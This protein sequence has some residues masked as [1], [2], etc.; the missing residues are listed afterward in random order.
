M[1]CGCF[2]GLWSLIDPPVQRGVRPH[3]ELWEQEKAMQRALQG[4][5]EA[6]IEGL[7]E[8]NGLKLIHF[9]LL[10][11]A[12]RIGLPAVLLVLVMVIP[13]CGMFVA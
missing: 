7:L 4:V 13:L 11:E 9:A 8:S 1:P 5:D 3:P 12:W 6:S 10:P 2:D